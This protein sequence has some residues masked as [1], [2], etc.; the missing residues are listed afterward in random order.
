[1]DKRGARSRPQ[2]VVSAQ[3]QTNYGSIPNPDQVLQQGE[4]GKN[5]CVQ[6][7][8]SISATALSG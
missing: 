8:A 6:K 5:L 4:D 2:P 7:D 1:M 3:A